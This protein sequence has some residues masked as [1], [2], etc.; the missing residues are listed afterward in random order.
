MDCIFKT[1]AVSILRKNMSSLFQLWSLHSS[2]CWGPTTPATL[3][4]FYQKYLVAKENVWG[5]FVPIVY[6]PNLL[7]NLNQKSMQPS[8]PLWKLLSD[9]I[10]VKLC[11]QDYAW[12]RKS[13]VSIPVVWCGIQSKFCVLLW[14]VKRFS[15]KKLKKLLWGC[16]YYMGHF[17][18][19]YMEGFLWWNQ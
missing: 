14:D 12:M 15:Y 4:I 18:G 6:N 11:V 16:N 13:V 9:M 7:C 3:C 10:L 19:G 8:L 5:I 17:S 2:L 1:K